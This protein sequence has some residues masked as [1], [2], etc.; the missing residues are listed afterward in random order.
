MSET[1]E[2]PLSSLSGLRVVELGVWVAAPSA[3]AM[4]A[5]WGADVV[6]VEGP[7]GDPMRNVFGSLGIGDDLPNP[8]FAL[9]NRG[10]RSVVL[11]LRA[12]GERAAF[13]DLLAGADVFV[14]NLRP[15]ALDKL[16]LEPH[17]TVGRHPHLVYCSVSGY[18]LHGEDRNRPAYDIG[19]FWA[20][21]GLS[22]QMADGEGSPLNARGGI[23][24]HITG[25]A[26]LSGILG[27]VLEQRATGQGRVVEVSLLRTGAYILGWDLGLQ[28]GLGKVAGAEPRQRTQAPLMNPYRAGDGRWFFLTGLEAGRHIASVCRALERPD[29]LEDPRFADATSIRR[30]R[31]E[32]IALLDGIIATRSFD[33]WVERFDAEGVWWAPAQAPPEVVGDPQLLAND[34]FVEVDGGAFRSVNSPVSFGDAGGRP[35]R[36]VRVPHL[37]E[38]T[39]EVLAELSE[40]RRSGHGDGDGA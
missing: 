18:G 39:D 38:H 27:A 19:A 24:D 21:S 29:L 15:D 28:M 2:G 26:A 25:L 22:M 33:E 34:G 10:K 11:D 31:V 12:E 14:T 6:K 9:D 23:G 13:E 30:N 3:A 32:V 40:R 20:R 37:G 36:Q 8:A 35:P 16:D 4:L 17:A 5:D 1:G 7:G